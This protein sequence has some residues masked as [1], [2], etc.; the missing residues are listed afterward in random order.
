MEKVGG[1]NA[2]RAH[3]HSEI[4]ARKLV[5][6]HRGAGNSGAYFHA[7]KRDVAGWRA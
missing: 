1:V 7:G 6:V 4:V 5:L 2:T 3:G